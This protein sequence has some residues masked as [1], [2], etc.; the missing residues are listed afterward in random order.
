M[1]IHISHYILTIGNKICATPYKRT[2]CSICLN[3]CSIGVRSAEMTGSLCRH[4]AAIS[5]HGE[6]A[7]SVTFSVCKVNRQAEVLKNW[8]TPLC[9]AAVR[10]KQDRNGTTDRL[11]I[12]P[13]GAAIL[14]CYV[15]RRCRNIGK[16]P[17][18]ITA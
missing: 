3:C 1:H 13:Q 12:L 11:A 17:L 16:W 4:T 9:S 14:F 10:L 6:L 18:P 8:R 2:S 7:R 15:Q 5:V